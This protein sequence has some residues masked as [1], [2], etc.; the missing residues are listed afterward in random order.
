VAYVLGRLHSPDS[1]PT[2]GERLIRLA[3]LGGAVVD[4][5]LS[6]RL[7]GAVDYRQD[8]DEWVVVLHGRATLDVEDERILLEAD[9]WILLPAGTPHRLLET[10]PGTSWLTVTSP[11]PTVANG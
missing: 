10:E 6:G 11:A 2:S 8:E 4:Q 5:I 7:D 9:D 1:A 3:H